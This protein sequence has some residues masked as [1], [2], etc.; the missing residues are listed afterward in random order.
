MLPLSTERS[1]QNSRSR[2]I[3]LSLFLSSLGSL[4]APLFANG[5]RGALP[6]AV[7]ALVHDRIRRDRLLSRTIYLRS[8]LYVSRQAAHKYI[9]GS[10]MSHC[11]SGTAAHVP[12]AIGVK[13]ATK[14]RMEVTR[15][16]RTSQQLRAHSLRGGTLTSSLRGT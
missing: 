7:L 2:K 11:R 15:P 8:G 13:N 5:G 1:T 12:S 6:L 9:L 10:T 16:L 14:R 3:A 4:V